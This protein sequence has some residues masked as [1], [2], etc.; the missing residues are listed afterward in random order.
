VAPEDSAS[1]APGLWRQ[2]EKFPERVARYH[3]ERRKLVNPRLH[4]ADLIAAQ[5][6]P[7]DSGDASQD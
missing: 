2:V 3:L 6:E 7:L 4:Q 5:T 1:G